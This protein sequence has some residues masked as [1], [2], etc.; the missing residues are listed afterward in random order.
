M[1]EQ[2]QLQ[3]LAVDAFGSRPKIV[4]LPDGV[5]LAF[6]PDAGPLAARRSL[7]HGRSWSAAAPVL[8]AADLPVGITGVTEALVDAAGELH[9]FLLEQW[10]PD[11]RGEAERGGVGAYAGWRIDIWYLRSSAERT[12]WSAPRRLW[13]GYTGALN[14]VIQLRSGRLVLP[15]SCYTQRTWADRGDGLDAFTFTGS[16]DCVSLCSDDG[17]DHWALSAPLRLPTPDITYAYGACEPVVLERRDGRVWMLIRSQTGRFWESFSPDGYDWSPPRPTAIVSSDSPAG[18]VRLPDGRLVLLWNACQRHPYAYGG[19]HVLHAALSADDGRT[20]RGWREVARDPQRH[21]PPPPSGDHGT[22][23]PFPV[24]TGDGAVLVCTGQ[25]EGRTILSRLAPDYLLATRQTT[26]WA[27]DLDDWSVFGTRGVA[28]QASADSPGGV[29]LQLRRTDRQFPAAAVWNL[30]LGPVGHLRLRLRRHGP[31]DD[32]VVLL[33]DHFSPPFDAE[34]DLHAVFAGRLA[35]TEPGHPDALAI[36]PTPWPTAEPWCECRLRWSL[37]AGEC[38]VEIGQQPV[39]HW[40]LRR[41]GP[42]VCY[43]R[44]RV[45]AAGP[46]TGA[47]QVAQIEADVSDSWRLEPPRHEQA[48]TGIL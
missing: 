6:A 43:L 2:A 36:E 7:D 41:R 14:S 16:F 3:P 20:W 13:E 30:P 42:G 22:A 17:G 32:L 48:G 34:A 27:R 25:G 46:Q 47:W 40:P 5:L 33:T 37:P 19:R 15:F 21:L 1:T 4:R 9:L 35:G 18:L 12:V 8:S 24:V 26:D 28:L 31:V 39:A 23:Y 29:A 44:L 45:D 10:R 11:A 38:V